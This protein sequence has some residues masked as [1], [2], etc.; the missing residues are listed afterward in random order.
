MF[1]I[2]RYVY[3]AIFINS[4]TVKQNIFS[5]KLFINSQFINEHLNRNLFFVMHSF[6]RLTTAGF[7]CSK[8]FRLSWLKANVVAFLREPMEEMG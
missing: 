2:L 5:N 7:K 1:T 8:L 3:H 4:I 6:R